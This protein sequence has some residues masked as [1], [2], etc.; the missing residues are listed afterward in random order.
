MCTEKDA[1]MK[2][3]QAESLMKKEPAKAKELFLKAGEI[4]LSMS[5]GNK[6]REKELID[7]AQNCYVKGK[8]IKLDQNIISNVKEEPNKKMKNLK[9]TKLSFKDIGGLDELKEE[10]RMKIIMPFLHPEIFKYY[11]KNIGGGILMYGPPGC[12]KSLIAEATAGEAGVAYFHVKASDIKSKYVGEAEQNIAALFEEARKASPAIIFFDE[13]ETLGGDRSQTA[14]NERGAITQLLTEMDGV[15]TK[16]QKILLLAATNEPWNIDLALRREGRFGKTIFVPPPDKDARVE[17]FKIH[18]K[19]R[20][21]DQNIKGKQL[22]ELTENYS[23]AD[24]KAVCEMASEIPLKEYF[25]TNVKR[26]INHDDFIKVIDCHESIIKPWFTKAIEELKSKNRLQFFEDLVPC[27]E[28][29][30]GEGSTKSK[31]VS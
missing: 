2:L 3:K 8:K 1:E 25:K 26:K 12:G 28:D 31:V 7:K 11:K 9:K 14:P 27:A 6:A 17:I 4:Y 23:G 15:G 5:M 22:L 13:F 20:P 10:I 19:G 16:D 21:I 29:V 24:L 30:M 18:L